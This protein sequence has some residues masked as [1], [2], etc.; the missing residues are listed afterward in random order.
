LEAICEKATDKLKAL[1]K[2]W[3]NVEM[4]FLNEISIREQR[5]QEVGCALT[6]LF[7]HLFISSQSLYLFR[8]S[9]VLVTWLKISRNTVK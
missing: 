6:F 9:H 7:F 8:E 5:K 4:P 3:E 2:E 1:E